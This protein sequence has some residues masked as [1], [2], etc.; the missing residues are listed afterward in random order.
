MEQ[1]QV[2]KNLDTIQNPP[3]CGN[4]RDE[5]RYSSGRRPDAMSRFFAGIRIQEVLPVLMR[6]L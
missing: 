4:S 3:G 6:F 1:A 2:K 5:N